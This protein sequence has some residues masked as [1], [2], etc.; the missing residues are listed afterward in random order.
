MS[1]SGNFPRESIRAEVQEYLTSKR[2]E[3]TDTIGRFDTAVI[4]TTFLPFFFFPSGDN[5]RRAIIGPPGP[6]GP[7]GH[8]GDRGERG[9]PGYS[10]SYSQQSQSYSQGSSH[11]GL[12]V[13]V[14]RVAEAMDYSSVARRVTDYIKSE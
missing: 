7:R 2:L 6:P 14:S 10:Q 4:N 12:Q 5:V 9:E 13:D 11:H 1:Y 3:A 8:K